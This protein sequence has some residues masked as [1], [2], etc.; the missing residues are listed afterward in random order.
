MKKNN[1]M[2]DGI[3]VATWKEIENNNYL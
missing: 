1:E 3:S 2:I